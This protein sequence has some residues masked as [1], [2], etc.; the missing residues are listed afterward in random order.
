MTSAAGLINPQVNHT[1]LESLM[2][3]VGSS[4]R[5]WSASSI[6]LRHADRIWIV[7]LHPYDAARRGAVFFPIRA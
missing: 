5:G 4:S 3:G 6:P 7:P 2:R 1:A